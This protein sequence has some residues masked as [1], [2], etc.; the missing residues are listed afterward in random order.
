MILVPVKMTCVKCLS[1]FDRVEMIKFGISGQINGK[2]VIHDDLSS[3]EYDEGFM[4][5]QAK[6]GNP[7]GLY[8]ANIDLSPAIHQ[9]IIMNI[10]EY[11]HCSEDCAGLC[12]GCGANLNVEK[13]KCEINET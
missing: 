4:K 3:D 12:Q 13:C 6:R 9:E 11:P 5:K 2:G 1:E 10:D 8:G 7:K